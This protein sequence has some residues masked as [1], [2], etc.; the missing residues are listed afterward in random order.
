VTVLASNDAVTIQGVLRLR[1]VQLAD[2]RR[3]RDRDDVGGEQCGEQRSQQTREDLEDLAMTE[4]IAGAVL[5]PFGLRANMPA[6]VPAES[7][8][9]AGWCQSHAIPIVVPESRGS[10][11]R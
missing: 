1:A 5:V 9:R 2:D 10:R 3:Q 8:R 11:A 7:Y 4:L 6:G